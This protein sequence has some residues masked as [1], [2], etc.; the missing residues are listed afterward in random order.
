[1][2]DWHIFLYSVHKQYFLL[3]CINKFMARIRNFK[4]RHMMFYTFDYANVVS[5][6]RGS[7]H[8]TRRLFFVT[9]STSFVSN[10]R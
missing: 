9:Q 10:C 1:M 8:F 3:L 6:R 2:L 5:G 7:N 4:K